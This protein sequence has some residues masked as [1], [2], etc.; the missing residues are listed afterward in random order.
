MVIKKINDELVNY[1]VE[2]Y[3][4]AE[5]LIWVEKDGNDYMIKTRQLPIEN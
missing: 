4:E 5:S 1:A 3:F 2:K